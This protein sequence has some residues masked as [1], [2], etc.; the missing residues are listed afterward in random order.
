MQ[1]KSKLHTTK[2]HK[3]IDW[4]K[5]SSF[6]LLIEAFRKPTKGLSINVRK[7]ILKKLGIITMHCKLQRIFREENGKLTH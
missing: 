4:E 2:T 7:L 6:N 3:S 1:G 5:F